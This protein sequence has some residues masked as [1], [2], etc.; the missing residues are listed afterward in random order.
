MS[1]APSTAQRN[2][3][4]DP[5]TPSSAVPISTNL[6]DLAALE[7]PEASAAT[8]NAIVLQWMKARGLH[9]HA[10]KLEEDIR[11]GKAG[12]DPV[13][14]VND[15][16]VSQGLD[17]EPGSS[18]KDGKDDASKQLSNRRMSARL[19]NQAHKPTISAQELASR[20]APRGAAQA[21]S[22]VAGTSSSATA[23]TGKKGPRGKSPVAKSPVVATQ[24][25]LKG[26]INTTGSASKAARKSPTP[27]ATPG[28]AIPDLSQLYSTLA[29]LM[30]AAGPS[31]QPK[32]DPQASTANLMTILSR[33][34]MTI[35]EAMAKDPTD[36]QYGYRDLEAWVEGTLDMYRVSIAPA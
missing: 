20:S 33:A 27:L 35:D 28:G 25:N 23:A 1:L 14:I 3:S 24:P 21:A 22:A 10:K 16:A 31:T 19:M 9:D 4:Q 26:T 36:K 13:V 30:T 32:E 7:S 6:P 18:T 5:P 17:N 2:A 15:P 12:T 8:Q 11:S 34:G 29:P